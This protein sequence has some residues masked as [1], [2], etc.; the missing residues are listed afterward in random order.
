M[1]RQPIGNQGSGKKIQ[2]V[3]KKWER[4]V[5]VTA[6]GGC[7]LPRTGV[8]VTANGSASY[9]ERGCQLPRTGVPVTA[10]GRNR[11]VTV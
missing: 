6:N 2:V 8:P 7:Q 5:P 3:E 11:T 4:G 10:N 9:R 1:K